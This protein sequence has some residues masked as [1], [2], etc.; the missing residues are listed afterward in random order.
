VRCG[1]L[2]EERVVRGI[3]ASLVRATRPFSHEE[4]AAFVI[5]RNERI[6]CLAWKPSPEPDM[7]RWDGP[8][9]EGTIA[10]VHTHPNWLPM[11]SNVDART[12]RET[13]LPVYVVTRS[14]I[15]KTNG[16]R[17]E[18]VLAGSWEEM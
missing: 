3:C 13:R 7:A 17:G 8:L 1:D 18:V 12:A 16:Q 9:P 11:P 14:R 4:R 6:Y 10:I 2:T 15:S 5:R